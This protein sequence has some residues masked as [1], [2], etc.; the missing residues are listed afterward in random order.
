MHTREPSPC[1]SYALA[2]KDIKRAT[3]S[4]KM[5][6]TVFLILF[7]VKPLFLSIVL[8]SGGDNSSIISF[9]HLLWNVLCRIH[10]E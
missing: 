4:A 7:M 6:V 2:G 3:I 1:V 9:D 10:L 8:I 5:T